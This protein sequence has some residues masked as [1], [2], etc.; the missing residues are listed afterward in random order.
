MRNAFQNNMSVDIKLPKTQLSK[1]IQ[2]G[3]FLGA[4]LSKIA[5]PVIKAV[6]PLDKNVLAPLVMTAAT[7][8]ID[9]GIQKK[10]HGSGI[11]L[12]IL[13]ILMY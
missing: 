11:T 5:G 10:I 2:S 4:L 12:V 9:I 3:G 13:K 7:S 8:A 6:V 1:K